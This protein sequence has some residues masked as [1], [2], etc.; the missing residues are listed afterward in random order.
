MSERGNETAGICTYLH[1]QVVQDSVER[2]T[3]MPMQG[4]LLRVP[5][6]SCPQQ[7][8]VEKSRNNPLLLSKRLHQTS[9][10]ML[11][12]LRFV[13]PPGVVTEEFM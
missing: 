9:G 12:N 3:L 11:C 8:A 6:R 7:R 5:A 2:R 1:L 10:D 4:N 13:I